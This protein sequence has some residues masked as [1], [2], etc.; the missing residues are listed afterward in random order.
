MDN[1][2]DVEKLMIEHFENLL[3]MNDDALTDDLLL[4][5]L[6]NPP[7]FANEVD[8]G[9][10]ELSSLERLAEE[11][12]RKLT[13]NDRLAEG[14]DKNQKP[15]VERKISSESSGCCSQIQSQISTDVD[16]L[17]LENDSNASSADHILSGESK[18]TDDTGYITNSDSSISISIDSSHHP[19]NDALLQKI[20]EINFASKFKRKP[21]FERTDA[22]AGFENFT[23][24]SSA[25]PLFITR[26]IKIK[27]SDSP[28][29]KPRTSNGG[30]FNDPF[31]P[32]MDESVLPAC[33]FNDDR[34]ILESI[35]PENFVLFGDDE[36]LATAFATLD[37]DDD[38]DDDDISIEPVSLSTPTKGIAVPTSTSA[39]Y[40]PS[41]LPTFSASTTCRHKNPDS[42]LKH[43]QEKTKTKFL[44]DAMQLSQNT[45][46]TMLGKIDSCVKETYTSD[47]P[48]VT[49]SFFSYICN[50]VCIP[51][52][53]NAR[54][55]KNNEEDELPDDYR[56][57]IDMAVYCRESCVSCTDPDCKRG[58]KLID[59]LMEH[60]MTDDVRKDRQSIAMINHWIEHSEADC[61]QSNCS[62]PWCLFFQECEENE[63][64]DPIVMLNLLYSVGTL[65][66]TNIYCKNEV[67]YRFDNE[68][69][70]DKRFIEGVD[71]KTICRHGRFGN[72]VRAAYDNSNI[73][74]WIIHKVMFDSE[75]DDMSIF[76]LCSNDMSN[77]IVNHFW[78]LL[79]GCFLSICVKY[80]SGGSLKQ[81]L[82]FLGCGLPD[83][84]TKLFFGQ[85]L[86]ACLFL[87]A[88]KIYYLQWISKNIVISDDGRRVKLS[89]FMP[90][91]HHKPPWKEQ[92]YILMGLPP[93][94]IPPEI[95]EQKEPVEKSDSWG[96]GHILYE[97]ITGTN[98]HFE[99]RHKS[100]AERRVIVKQSKLPTVHVKW[101]DEIWSEIVDKC[102]KIDATERPTVSDIKNIVSRHP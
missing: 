55:M 10:T 28:I 41:V 99:H 68:I 66:F 84:T 23:A 91:I 101:Q 18:E 94:V 12:Y 92:V 40:I 85:M 63:V 5:S 32:V 51:N 9:Q 27:P 34:D 76:Y 30:Y 93:E 82:D 25:A 89:Y 80:E 97:M 42:Y 20:T 71:W 38:D 47:Q 49:M 95:Y 54:A 102:W 31:L 70:E 43:A 65:Y 29:L 7:L 3:S 6:E 46:Q 39:A 8:L 53:P 62:I 64:D 36:T 98:I 79:Q 81:W 57:L 14:E 13:A 90:R 52:L 2:N 87:H 4:L 67:F 96:L 75:F 56:S 33:E 78:A 86:E 21:E 73:P 22:A 100:E 26:G 24:K 74:S 77:H 44:R 17:V 16:S 35:E 15:I 48:S 61:I 50:D 1:N 45:P 11:T 59:H 88:E 37:V 19:S 83:E 58:Q 72:S 60:L 69:P